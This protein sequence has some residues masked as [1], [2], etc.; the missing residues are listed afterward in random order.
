MLKPAVRC[1]KALAP[2]QG[3]EAGQGSSQD[4][5]QQVALLSSR[6]RTN[7][8]Y[9]QGCTLWLASCPP[10][11]RGCTSLCKG[12]QGS[13]HLPLGSSSRWGL[14]NDCFSWRSTSVG[15]AASSSLRTCRAYTG[16]HI[17][18]VAV[19]G[20]LPD[21]SQRLCTQRGI[22]QVQIMCG[23]PDAG[24]FHASRKASAASYA[25]LTLVDEW[26]RLIDVQP[27]QSLLSS[28][29]GGWIFLTLPSPA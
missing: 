26:V 7:I 24:S 19:E 2:V 8:R 27:P 28:L 20:G 10:A 11:L 17:V 12:V 23:I 1:L 9:D 21:Q 29:Q 15:I 13:L 6:Q 4:R 14:R 22:H 25:V 3:G 5:L 18:G 16:T